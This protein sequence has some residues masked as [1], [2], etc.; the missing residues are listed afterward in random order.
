MEHES[1]TSGIALSGGGNRAAL[2]ALGSL[3]YFVDAEKNRSTCSISSVSGGSLTNGYVAQLGEFEQ[4]TSKTFREGLK[5]LIRCL[6][7]SSPLWGWCGTWL[8]LAVVIV[9]IAGVFCLGICVDLA[10]LVPGVPSANWFRILVIVVGLALVERIL[11]RNRTVVVSWAVASK[12][13]NNAGVNTLLANT[14]NPQVDHVICSTNL[15]SGKHFY[16]SGRFVYSYA[17]GGGEPGSF[18]LHA[19]VQVSS[20]FPGALPARWIRTCQFHF[21]KSNA[22][23]WLAFVDGGVYDNMGEQWLVNDDRKDRKDGA[24]V[25]REP[26]EVIIVNS[27]ANERHSSLATLSLPFVGELF[28]LVRII[29]TLFEN[30]TTTRRQYLFS[31]FQKNHPAGCF[32][33][34]DQKPYSVAEKLKADPQYQPRAAAVRTALANQSDEFWDKLADRTSHAPTT[35]RG[36]GVDCATDLLWHGYLNAMCNSHVVLGYPLLAV[37]TREQIRQYVQES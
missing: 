4:Q 24:P 15:N 21:K 23:A 35:F 28:G 12:L 9:A 18:P 6:A 27:S 22:P 25:V 32:V 30:T 34:I 2:F 29:N 3:L 37:P 13:F 20:C 1:R 19:A 17:T 31:R 10:A 11:I 33:T 26:Q 5:P 7:K 16:F 14:A 36:M 8:Y